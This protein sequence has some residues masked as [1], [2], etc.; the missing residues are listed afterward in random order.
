M[1]LRSICVFCGSSV[2][3]RPEYAAAAKAMGGL[4]AERGIRVVYGG[5]NVGLMG[6][7]ADAACRPAAR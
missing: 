1:S 3:G 6:V 5:G 4:L 7:L 2:G